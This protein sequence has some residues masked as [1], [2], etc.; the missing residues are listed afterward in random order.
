MRRLLPST[1]VAIAVI[2][3]GC[4]P[5]KTARGIDTPPS[6]RTHP[7]SSPS[8]SVSPVYTGPL[9]PQ[10]TGPDDDRIGP[11]NTPTPTITGSVPGACG[12]VHEADLVAIAHGP[13]KLNFPNDPVEENTLNVMTGATSHCHWQFGTEWI[14]H[15]RNVGTG[16][17]N[18]QIQSTGVEGFVPPQPG[19]GTPVDGIG[20]GAVLRNAKLYVR[21]GDGMLTVELSIPDGTDDW[22]AHSIASNEQLARMVV[23]RIRG[24]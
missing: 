21:L 24:R 9:D 14:D 12:L 20:D 17:L 3:T 4:G 19:V 1:A 8:A 22:I 23:G 5:D 16:I 13:A 6:P 11:T 7:T 18:V 15:G 10:P 2:L